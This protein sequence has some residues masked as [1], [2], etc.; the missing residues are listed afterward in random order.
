MSV[1]RLS[2]GDLTDTVELYHIRGD[3]LFIIGI[4]V[5]VLEDDSSSHTGSVFY[6]THLI[7]FTKIR[8]DR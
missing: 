2:C 5:L 8:V 6:E 3:A 1:D 7:Q 4:L